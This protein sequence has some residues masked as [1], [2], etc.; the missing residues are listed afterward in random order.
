MQ[1]KAFKAKSVRSKMTDF[2]LHINNKHE[3]EDRAIAIAMEI[4][5]LL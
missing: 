4:I 1:K 2:C 3:I 5:F